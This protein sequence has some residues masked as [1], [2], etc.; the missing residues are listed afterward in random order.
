MEKFTGTHN[1]KKY[2]SDLPRS[3]RFLRC[4]NTSVMD[5]ALGGSRR[6]NRRCFSEF[7]S[8]AFHFRAN[9]SNFHQM[10]IMCS[11]KKI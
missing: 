3:S 1:T 9:K 10:Q 8:E 7:S 2:T 11:L 4:S 5:E 6:F